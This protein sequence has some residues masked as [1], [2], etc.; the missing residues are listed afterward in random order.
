MGGVP[1]SD[2]RR[3]HLA[4]VTGLALAAASG[5]A[6]A[7]TITVALSGDPAPGLAGVNFGAISIEL[8]LNN[9][10]QVAFLSFLTG[11]GVTASNDGAIWRDSTLIAR[12]GN[13]APGFSGVNF[14]SLLGPPVLND[15]GQVA[16]RSTL[17]GSGVTSTNDEGIWR[18]S[19]LIVREGIDARGLGSANLGAPDFRLSLNNTGQVAFVSLVAGSGV[20]ATNDTAIMR[21]LTLVAREG[22]AAPGL[23]FVDLGAFFP[24]PV[25]NDA[26]QVAFH[27]F[28]VDT[29]FGTLTSSI[30][31]DSTLIARADNAAPGLPG[32]TFLGTSLTPVLNNTGQVAFTSTLT[33]SG[34][35]ASNDRAIWRDSTL[36]VREGN[37]APGLGGVNF[38]NLSTF[39]GSH[40]NALGLN[41]NGQVAF[42]SDLTGSGV[43]STNDSAIWRDSTLIARKGNAA[44]GLGGVK[45]GTFSTSSNTLVLNGTGQVAFSNVLTGSGVTDLNDLSFWLGDGIEQVK[46]AREGDSLAGSTIASLQRLSQGQLTELNNYGQVAYNAV[47]ADG[48]PGVFLFTPDLHY[49]SATS[50]NWDSP[51]NWT[52]SL[53]PAQVHEVFIDPASSL[54]VFG[55]VGAVT[56]RTLTVGGGAGIGTLVLNG[57]TLTA[58]DGTTVTSTGVLTGHGTIGGPVTLNAGGFIAPGV[59]PGL[60]VIEG[61]LILDGGIVLLEAFGPGDEDKIRVTGNALFGA[62]VIRVLLGYQ[63]DP[64][65]VFDFFD[66]LGMTT[67][68]GDFGGIEAL[69][70]LGSGAAGSE[71]M[72]RLGDRLFTVTAAGVPEP[73]TLALVCLALAGVLCRR[74]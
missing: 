52:L 64:G 12:E 48:R 34:V 7:G 10:G 28:L 27:S 70:L 4:L 21:N 30:W 71:I 1:C 26:G 22:D 40:P 67:I 18:N 58:T 66:V 59:S 54:T 39:S 23:S 74:R 16:F 57:G 2:F 42:L 38:G 63:P 31:R 41:D 15:T 32:V 13:A 47:L 72:V 14:G 20:T 6:A 8:S 55:P 65:Y 25:L 60:I 51:G 37:A 43:T 36:I 69:A 24:P 56:V 17:T 19:T 50:G 73:G 35:T 29:N 68:Q 45:F 3:G 49:R 5:G 11:S 9:A 53:R 62:A 46:V 44:P 33:G 61:D